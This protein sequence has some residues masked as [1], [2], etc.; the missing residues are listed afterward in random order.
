MVGRVIKRVLVVDDDPVLRDAVADHVADYG[1]APMLAA[2]GAEA[3]SLLGKG[4]RPAAILLDV[5]MPRM[6]GRDLVARLRR[7]P[8]L[9]Q[10]PV[11]LMTA[12]T[13]RGSLPRVDALLPKPFKA[14]ELRAAL[15]ALGVLPP[16]RLRNRPGKVTSH[17]A[18]R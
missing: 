12:V 4:P 11:I 2:D 17:L 13:R 3:L 8:R 1:L 18:G 10:I 15:V 5:L 14:E 16:T 6:G 9:A 7:I